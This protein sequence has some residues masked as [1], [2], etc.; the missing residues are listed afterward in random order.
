MS[1]HVITADAQGARSV[2]AADLDGDGDLDALSASSSDDA[3]RWYEKLGGGVMQPRA[4]STSSLG[5]RAV[6]A[7]DLDGDADTPGRTSS[8]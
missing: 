8:S 4:I 6:H 7:A 3:V 2:H 5:A 1:T